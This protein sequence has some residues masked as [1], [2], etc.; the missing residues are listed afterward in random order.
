MQDV[1]DYRGAY[2]DQDVKLAEVGAEPVE[3]GDRK[4]GEDPEQ[5]EK[6]KEIAED[7]A[8]AAPYLDSTIAPALGVK[9]EPGSSEFTIE[10]EKLTL[11]DH[12]DNIVEVYVEDLDAEFDIS[13][14]EGGRT[15]LTDA[16]MQQNLMA[17]MQPLMGLWEVV[18]KG[19]PPAVLARNYMQ[20]IA[21]RF[22]LPRDLYPDE[23]ESKLER[24][25]QPEAPSE[26]PEQEP[27]P[28]QA[29]PQQE[30]QPPPEGGGE[31]PP[32]EMLQ[33]ILQLPPAQALRVLAKIFQG[34]E[35]MMQTLQ[36]ISQLPPEEQAAMIEQIVMSLAQAQQGGP[37]Q[38][39]AAPPPEGA[40]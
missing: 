39:A 15:P 10:Q 27:A 4:V 20:V 40:M 36:Q 1:G 28:S 22:D 35:Q 34:D 26:A 32:E 24:E 2:A 12:R 18:Q 13:F 7:R 21:E 9:T 11:K 6:H 23:L 19:G 29:P 3:A 38:E 37:P 14:V 5:D 33:K 17:L 30:G 31:Q 25:P 16:A 8:L